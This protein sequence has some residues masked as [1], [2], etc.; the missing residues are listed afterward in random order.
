MFNPPNKLH[1][2][3]L[4]V[5]MSGFSSFVTADVQCGDTIADAQILTVALSCSE[6]PAIRVEG[7]NGNLTMS[8]NGAVECTT[9]GIGIHMLGKSGIVM[10]G[11]VTNC[12]LGLLL[13]GDGSHKVIGVTVEESSSA[14]IF[15]QSDG[16]LIRQNTV[17]NTS[18]VIASGL[19]L[20][21]ERNV[22][23]GNNVSGFLEYGIA[24][25]GFYS[26]IGNNYVENSE[27][28]IILGALVVDGES[29]GASYCVIESNT[30]V[31]SLRTG[32]GIGAPYTYPN[33]DNL[34]TGNTVTGSGN[35]DILDDNEESDCSDGLNV[36]SNNTADTS[37][38]S[39]LKNL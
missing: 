19:E 9:D 8:G 27:L 29:I 35:D 6:D 11:L 23:V 33:M 24:G 22:A 18:N 13:D 26:Y 21:G 31:G 28:G 25:F 12:D 2:A 39:C 37:F 14:A 34:V 5:L 20:D 3:G 32:I 30:V 15:A 7:P 1:L 36:W 4:I 38:P 10:G 16:N 17:S